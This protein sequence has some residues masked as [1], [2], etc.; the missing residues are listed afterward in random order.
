M[1]NVGLDPQ[2]ALA[3]SNRGLTY[4]FLGDYQRAIQDLDE[5]I[6]LD[7]ELALAYANRAINYTISTVT[8]PPYLW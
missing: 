1:G 5:A 8:K 3:Y 4:V 6:R 7:P 2:L